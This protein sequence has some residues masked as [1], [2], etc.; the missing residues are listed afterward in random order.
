MGMWLST[1]VMSIRIMVMSPTADSQRYRKMKILQ[2]QSLQ[3]GILALRSCLDIKLVE[4][5]D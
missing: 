1:G 2:D 5:S 4:M 3:L